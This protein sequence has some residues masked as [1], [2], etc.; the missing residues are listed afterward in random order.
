MEVLSILGKALEHNGKPKQ[1]AIQVTPQLKWPNLGDEGP[2]SRQIQ[3]FYDKYERICGLANDGQWMPDAELLRVL[4][5][6]LK[7]SR[8][9][10][11]ENQMKIAR[12]SGL[13]LT[14]PRKVYVAIKVKV[15]RDR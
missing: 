8:A 6:C 12:R 5:N 10:V 15:P 3:E 1:S 2:E 4:G 14:K 7:G 11:Y 9:R 13:D